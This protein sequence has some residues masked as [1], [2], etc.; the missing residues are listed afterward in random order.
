VYLFTLV[1]TII[2]W[3]IYLLIGLFIAFLAIGFIIEIT[4][5][6]MGFIFF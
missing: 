6:I 1:L 5:A 3:G 2:V 4:R